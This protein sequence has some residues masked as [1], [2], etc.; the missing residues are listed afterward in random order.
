M[1]GHA[2]RGVAMSRFDAT[3]VKAWSGTSSVDDGKTRVAAL[4]GTDTGLPEP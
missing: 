2:V 3:L 4:H 1:F